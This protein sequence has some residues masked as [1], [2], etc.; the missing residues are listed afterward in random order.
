MA[1][2]LSAGTVLVVPEDPTTRFAALVA[3]E[4]A[5]LP[6]DTACLLIA[7][8]ALEG[9]DVD[10]ELRRLDDLAASVPGDCVDA[11]V[12][13]LCGELGFAGD[14]ASYHDPRNSL[15][16]V[17]L[18]R[19]LGLPISLAIVAIEVGRRR[20]VPIVG[21]GMPGHFLVRDEGSPEEFVDLFA[22]GERLDARGCRR[23]FERI[24]ARA[25]WD[26]S[27]LIPVGPLL[28]VTRVVA[29]LL[30]AYRRAGDRRSLMW[31]LDLRLRLPG[32]TDTER[33]ELGVLLGSSGRFDHGAD[34]LE[35]T[36]NDDD[37]R[38]AALL[39]ARLN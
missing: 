24:H 15:L 34:V 30:N 26:D 1:E 9:L 6:L 28:I 19:R 2:N 17:V 37:H 25:E 39:R 33:R 4:G 31:A 13:H 23:L 38:S 10:A 32:A 27:F 7:A 29:N 12:D 22:G 18:D 14:Q 16:P 36:G 8:H 3:A 5:S 35:S 11:I 20:D 21:I